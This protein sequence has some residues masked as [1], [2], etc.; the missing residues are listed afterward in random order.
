[1]ILDTTYLLLLARIAIDIDLLGAIAK[2]KVDLKFN[3]ITIS[4]ISLFELQ[5]KATKLMIPVKFIIEAIKAIFVTFRI[6]PFYKPEIIEVSYR[7]RKLI[8]D[9]IDCVI[10]ATAIVM[11]EDLVT[12]DSLILAN[13][14]IIRNKYGIKVLSFKDIKKDYF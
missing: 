4:L 10:L 8:Q 3:E 6:E 9:Y 12:E 5:A 7:L 2:G 11:K 14:E 13:M 1:M